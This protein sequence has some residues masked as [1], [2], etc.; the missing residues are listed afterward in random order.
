MVRANQECGILQ[1][2]HVC[3][4]EDDVISSQEIRRFQLLNLVAIAGGAVAERDNFHK[5]CAET[6]EFLL[7]PHAQCTGEVVNKNAALCLKCRQ[8]Q[9]PVPSL[10]PEFGVVVNDTGDMHL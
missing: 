2:N 8:R 4:R 9:K 5:R 3:I 7:D 6:R 1:K 10:H